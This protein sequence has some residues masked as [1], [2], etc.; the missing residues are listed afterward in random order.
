MLVNAPAALRRATKMGDKSE[1]FCRESVAVLGRHPQVLPPTFDLADMVADL[2]AFDELRPRIIELTNLLHRMTVTRTA[3]G[4]DVMAAALHGYQLLQ[5]AGKHH[6]L[7]TLRDG[8]APRFRAQG[9]RKGG[10]NTPPLTPPP[11]DTQL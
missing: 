10:T 1:S 9:R 4:A 2:A 3:L 11:G 7:Q 5:V 6:G 8:L